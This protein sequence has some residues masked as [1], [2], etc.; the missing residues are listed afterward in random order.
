MTREEARKAFEE[1]N[2]K[3]EAEHKK[4]MA[5]K[6]SDFDDPADYFKAVVSHT[7]KMVEYANKA[8]EYL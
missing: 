5:L 3:A 4:A 2:E 6:L 7:S 1:F 8:S